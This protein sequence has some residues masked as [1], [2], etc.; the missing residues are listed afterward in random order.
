MIG[1]NLRPTEDPNLWALRETVECAIR[2]CTACLY[3]ILV[4]AP[5]SLNGVRVVPACRQNER[6]ESCPRFQ[7]RTG[8]TDKMGVGLYD[9]SQKVLIVGDGDFSFSLSL[10]NDRVGSKTGRIDLLTC[11]S[12]HT[13]EHLKEVY[14]DVETNISKLKEAGAVVIHEVD[15]TKL[16]S[17]ETLKS[18]APFDK[19]IFNFPCVDVPDGKDGQSYDLEANRLLVSD[20]LKQSEGLLNLNPQNLG[21]VHVTH[22]TKEPFS[23][24]KI[25]TLC[26]PLNNSLKYER[27]VVFD[28]SCYPDY[29][30]RKVNDKKTFP[31]GDA[32][33]HIFSP[34]KGEPDLSYSDGVLSLDK[35]QSINQYVKITPTRLKQ[36]VCLLQLPKAKRKK[37]KRTD[38]ANAPPM[39][40]KKHRKRGN[41]RK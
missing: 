31:V 10:A 41:K 35:L 25:P 6:P 14:P 40:P 18:Q 39:K 15:A 38:Y 29:R 11:T 36:F 20:F 16:E 9:V 33:T 13:L 4:S 1:E 28:R 5:K 3:K 12:F 37:E 32:V 22:K 26:D 7:R 30:P 27:S 19:I 8:G 21:E 34:T 2:G 17:N 24:W 23:W